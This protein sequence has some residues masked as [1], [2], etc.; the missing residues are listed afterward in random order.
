MKSKIF[1]S[2]ALFLCYLFC[3]QPN[4]HAQQNQGIGKFTTIALSDVDKHIGEK[5]QVCG[6]IFGGK[7]L[8]KSDKKV[9]LL[10][11]GA[12]F[13]NAPLTLAIPHSDSLNIPAPPEQYFNNQEVCVQGLLTKYKDKVIIRIHHL[14]QITQQ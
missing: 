1:I 6:K 2:S 10:N 14:S 12:P 5:V 13:P 3:V 7:F 11:M 9:T 8:A 4:V